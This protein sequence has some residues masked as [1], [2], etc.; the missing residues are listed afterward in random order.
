[1]AKFNEVMDK[2][3]ARQLSPVVLAFVGD[4]AYSLYV[5]E[6]LVLSA[7]R[8]TGELQ[9]LSSEKVSAKGQAALFARMEG[10][11]DETEREIFLRG[12]YA[13]KPTRSKSASVAEYNVST[14]FEAVIGYLYLT[15]NYGRLDELLSSA[16]DE[17]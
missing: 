6:G 3:R 16:D 5:R 1:M 9:K 8:K 2:E 4:A 11:L 10:R 17:N 7:E 13:K 15:G 14:G 12:R